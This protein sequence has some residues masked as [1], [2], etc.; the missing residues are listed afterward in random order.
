MTGNVQTFSTPAKAAAVPNRAAWLGGALALLLIVLWPVLFENEFFIALGTMILFTAI[1]ST[2][3]HLI[4]RM[5]HVSLAHAGFVGVG[6]YTSVL[7][8]MKLGVPFPL[9]LLAGALA[10]ALLAL[11][12]GPILLRLSGKYFVLATFL[13]GEIIRMVFTEWSSLTGGANG[14]FGIPSPLPEINSPIR[15]YYFTAVVAV[16]CLAFMLRLLG[17]EIGRAIDSMR[18]AD[19]VAE[20]SGVPVT[21]LKVIVFVIACGLAGVQGGLQAYYLKYIDPTAFSGIQ[22]LDLVVMNVVGGMDRVIGVFL[23]TLFLVAVP[24]FLRGYVE[25]QYVIFGIVLIIVVAAMPGGLVEFAGRV[26]DWIVPKKG[27]EHEA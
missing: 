18:E 19:R 11:A 3:L 25:L 21:R 12:I 22:S 20:C 23:G 13:L 10:A 4:I 15:F 5:G 2:S 6:A 17:S 7:T 26:R 27:R 1:G 8:L 16:A 14:I 24:E 9:N